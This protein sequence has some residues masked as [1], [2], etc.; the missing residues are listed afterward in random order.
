MDF[1]I[2]VCTVAI[3]W[4][5]AGLL[6]SVIGIRRLEGRNHRIGQRGN[7]YNWQIGA[8]MAFLGPANIASAL[9]FTER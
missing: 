9:L 2:I 5:S 6:G 4:Y 7:R 8:F 1:W 3:L